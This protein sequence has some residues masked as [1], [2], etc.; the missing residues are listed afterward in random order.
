MYVKTER[1]KWVSPVPFV[2]ADERRTDDGR[3]EEIVPLSDAAAVTAGIDGFC[4]LRGGK[5][6][7]WRRERR[8]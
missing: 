4:L 6:L 5:E 3:T 7:K 8:L 2:T 1:S